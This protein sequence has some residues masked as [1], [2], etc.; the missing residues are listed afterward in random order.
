VNIVSQTPPPPTHTHTHARTHTRRLLVPR[1]LRLMRP[2]RPDCNKFQRRGTHDPDGDEYP[3]W[4]SRMR[5]QRCIRDCPRVRW[6]K[7]GAWALIG[8]CR[9]ASNCVGG[10]NGTVLAV[11]DHHVAVIL[12]LQLERPRAAT[13]WDR[14]VG[15]VVEVGR[16]KHC[17]AYIQ[18]AAFVRLGR[19]D[20]L[21]RIPGLG[22]LISRLWMMTTQCWHTFVC[23]VDQL[24]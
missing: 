4:R 24:P 20:V 6:I 11:V 8:R 12:H 17:S 23:H 18:P 7:F 1:Q 3:R 15:P 22:L 14:G 2:S 21:L 13:W 5:T 10:P 19:A 9:L 16:V